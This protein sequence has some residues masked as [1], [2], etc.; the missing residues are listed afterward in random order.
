MGLTILAIPLIILGVFIKPY[1]LENSRCISVSFASARPFC[2]E[3]A[4]N[5]PEVIKYGSVLAGFA[6]IYAGR[7]QIRRQR[8]GK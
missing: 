1:A 6:L 8:G 7:L 3:R 2:F 5:M 4:S